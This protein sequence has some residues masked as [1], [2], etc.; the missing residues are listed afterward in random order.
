MII[1]RE[2]V[3]RETWM[4][5]NYHQQSEQRNNVYYTLC[6]IYLRCNLLR[7]IRLRCN[8]QL[9]LITGEAQITIYY[10]IIYYENISRRRQ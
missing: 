2:I 8:Y 1:S 7:V 9:Q 5:N 6:V 10:L 4:E 3:G